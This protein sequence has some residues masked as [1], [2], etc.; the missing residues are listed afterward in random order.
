VPS[1]AQ[2]AGAAPLAPDPCSTPG[3]LDGTCVAP[4][5]CNGAS[6]EWTERALGGFCSNNAHRCCVKVPL[7][8]RTSAVASGGLSLIANSAL[9]SC[10][11]NGVLGVC[12][13]ST[14]PSACDGGRGTFHRGF[15][16]GAATTQ[17]CLPAV[18]ATC[19]VGGVSGRCVHTSLCRGHSTSGFCAGGADIKCCTST[20]PL[21][22]SNDCSA[23]NLGSEESHAAYRGGVLIGNIRTVM[24]GGKR[25]ERN[26]ACALLDMFRAAQTSGV[27][28]QLN[29]G[30]RTHKEQQYFWNCY[31]T[32]SCNDGNLA[33][34]PGYSNH[35]HGIAVDL[36]TNDGR[37][38]WLAD[39]ADTHG[40][41]RTV[42]SEPWHWEYR[43]G[44]QRAS[45]T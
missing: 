2:V 23:R 12:Q 37:Y 34:R 35:Q 41:V 44:S 9:S 18:I 30:F 4:S 8:N 40:F 32:Q 45:Y 16:S 1:A 14:R 3:G 42:P 10:V 20:A 5:A 21:G 36:A 24:V 22:A 13:D 6:D 33:A 15:C 17:C 31:Q 19:S 26:T 25:V 11:V 38:D 39:Y 28:L 7:A 27:R 43:P 29:S